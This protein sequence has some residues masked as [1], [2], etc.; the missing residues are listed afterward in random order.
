[1]ENLLNNSSE[2]LENQKYTLE[3][4]SNPLWIVLQSLPYLMEYE[5]ECAEQTFARY[6]ANLIAGEIIEDNEKINSV[7]ESWKNN[8][9]RSKFNFNEDLKSI[10]LN[11]TPWLFDVESDE[12]K[13]MKLALLLDLNNLE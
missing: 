5:H 7:L 13:N 1:F 4:S 9:V 12:E 11:E 8:D 10:A 3:Y 2:S 6:Y